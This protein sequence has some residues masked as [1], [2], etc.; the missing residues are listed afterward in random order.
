MHKTLLCAVLAA[1]LSVFAQ[2]P[3]P[4]EVKHE[5]KLVGVSLFDG[6]VLVNGNI[7][8]SQKYILQNCPV[9]SAIKY[10]TRTAADSAVIK[11]EFP[12]AIELRVQIDFTYGFPKGSKVRLYSPVDNFVAAE[13]SAPDGKWYFLAE[14]STPYSRP[15]FFSRGIIYPWTGSSCEIVATAPGGYSHECFYGIAGDDI[16]T[17]I[18]C[19]RKSMDDAAAALKKAPGFFPK[20]RDVI[21][22]FDESKFPKRAAMKG[23]PSAPSLKYIQRTLKKME[24][25]TKENPATVRVLFYG[26]SI[27]WQFWSRLLMQDLKEKY[28]TVNFVWKNLAIGGFE[29][30]R[31]RDSFRREVSAFYPDLLFFHDYGDVRYYAEMVKWAREDT[32]AEIVLWTSHLASYDKEPDELLKKRDGRSLAILETA[33]K[34][35]CHIID[36]NDKWCRHLV[37]KKLKKGE[38]LADGIHLNGHGQMQYKEFIQEELIRIPGSAGDEKATGSEKFYPFGKGD[39]FK[40]NAD[41]SLEFT[42]TGNRVM[43]VSDG[44]ADEKLDAEILL[45]GKKMA[46]M[47]SLW[48]I[49]RPTPLIMWFP[50]L[51][52]VGFGKNPPVAE[53]YT[54]EILPLRKGDPTNEVMHATGDSPKGSM[55]LPFR[56][57]LTGSRSGNMGEGISTRPFESH[58]RRITIPVRAWAMWPHWKGSR[59]KVGAKTFFSVHPLFT[60][61]LKYTP[62]GKETLVVQGCENSKHTLTIKLP[63]GARSGIKGFRVWT[64]SK[65]FPDAQVVVKSGDNLVQS[66]GYLRSAM[67]PGAKGELILEDGVYHVPETITF[68]KK[69]SGM[70]IRARNP[71]KAVITTG[72]T[73]KGSDMRPVKDKRLL[74]RLQESVR[75]K[76][77]AIRIP[78]ALYA[79]RF[80]GFS[81]AIHGYIQKSQPILTVDS[82]YQPMAHWPNGRERWWLSKDMLCGTV[83]REVVVYGKKKTVKNPYFK[84]ERAKNWD[85]ASSEAYLFGCLSGW[86]YEAG[87]AGVFASDKGK[88]IVEVNRNSPQSVNT[89]TRF[90]FF[91]LLEEIDEPGEWAYDTKSKML[92]LYPQKG[93]SGKSRCS[94]GFDTPAVF[95][96]AR[97]DGM[98]FEGLVFTGKSGSHCITIDN[99]NSNTVVGCRFSGLRQGV[100]VNGY[101]NR[102]LS[103]D[104]KN[105]LDNGVSIS[106]GK[107]RE[108]IHAGNVV[109]NCHFE[110]FGI[111]SGGYADAVIIQY[112]SCGNVIRHCLMH[113][114]IGHAV[115]VRGPENVMEYCRV[116]DVCRDHDDSGAVYANGYGSYGTVFRYNDISTSVGLSSGIYLDDFCCGSTVYGNILRDIGHFGV[117][118]SGGRDITVENN[119]FAGCWGGIRLDNRGLFWPAWKDRAKFW[120][121]V[122]RHFG[123]NEGS[124]FVKAHPQLTQWMAKDGTNMITGPVDNT[125]RNNLFLDLPG[126]ST[127]FLVCLK[128][129]IPDGRTT[130]GG[131][132]YVRTKG[133]AKGGYDFSSGESAGIPDNKHSKGDYYMRSLDK[134]VKVLD[135]TSENPI[136]LGFVRVPKR[137]F[138]VSDYYWEQQGWVD[139][140]KLRAKREKGYEQGPYDPGD[141]T[142]KPGAR[143]LKEMPGF[144]P[145]PFE[146]IGLYKDKWRKAL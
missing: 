140:D 130:T 9:D 67:S 3:K 24:E 78:D 103:C 74:G 68:R 82:E 30:H 19:S 136:D 133:L 59:P 13:V 50:G 80:D 66:I 134:D 122:C 70:V 142:L 57:K 96:L 102:I 83:D 89:Y 7:T 125:Y 84:V 98:R 36:L 8:G 91:N 26:Q 145:I 77:V 114:T 88:D 55:L 81:R 23:N 124:E 39:A 34:Y 85:L 40:T 141:F 93:F 104:F 5:G 32:A 113:G 72:W 4:A 21:W 112:N 14:M 135:G 101:H 146:K 63:K 121:D 87:P 52:S 117:F 62:A 120:N 108:R 92:V 99:G 100:S 115:D 2:A 106:G 94:V 111:L 105:L 126:Y 131:S 54:L 48:E 69:D 56:F 15:S 109:E 11:W 119:I 79:K 22:Q 127:S 58:G 45:D 107:F 128:R 129:D 137:A 64:P 118:L 143:L 90:V 71:G 12:K 43:L 1:S 38:Y 60:D 110:E 20:K 25:S 46:S 44:T 49:T 51:Q 132:M 37:D 27:V 47:S 31:L 42:F 65:V 17:K 116:Y 53:D 76:C 33:E 29:A 75:G 6:K 97:C 123:V 138:D 144:K 86:G 35:H 73:F 61:R 16:Q 95:N 18:A 28:P 10:D 139:E 41:G